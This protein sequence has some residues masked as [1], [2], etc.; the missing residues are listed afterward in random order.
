MLKIQL[1][2]IGCR[3]SRALK[4]NLMTALQRAPFDAV[5]EEIRDVNEIIKYQIYSTPALVINGKVTYQGEI[6][7]VAELQYLLEN[8]EYNQI[9]MRKIIVP[10]DFSKN[11]ASAF[12]FAQALARQF[13]ASV[14]LLHVY[15]PSFDVANPY[16]GLPHAEFEAMK[17]KQMKAFYNEYLTISEERDMITDTPLQTE[18]QV[19]FAAEE[20]V[21]QSTEADLIV[22]GTTGEGNILEQVFG[23]V[24]S[25][26]AQN[27][28]CPVLLIPPGSK[29]QGF[30]KIVYASNHQAA[31][32]VLIK[33][34][35]DLTGVL[36]AQI[37]FIHVQPEIRRTEYPVALDV[38]KDIKT[39][40][41]TSTAGMK[42][43]SVSCD[44]IVEGI[45]YYVRDNEADLVV[46][47][48]IHRNTL[49]KLFHRSTTRRMVF[50]TKAPLLVLHY[51]D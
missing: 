10:T 45:S 21:R 8:Y 9:H 34:V 11:S 7:G 16:L 4:A 25:H 38:R 36:P 41:A 32:E 50:N 22:M 37:H 24:S 44:D 26:V 12:R 1:L 49:A 15:H 31:D 5:V 48:T 42:V 46:M 13:D 39:R 35:I 6:P 43:V 30:Q 51:D 14:K 47:G 40:T 29:Y 18:L 2:G 28:H 19:G 20:I 17:A 3:K 23:K 33:Q 27:A